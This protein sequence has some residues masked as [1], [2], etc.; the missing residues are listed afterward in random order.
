MATN[1]PEEHFYSIFKVEEDADNAFLRN[2]SNY[3]PE[4]AAS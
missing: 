2:F 4:Y 1:V 3:L